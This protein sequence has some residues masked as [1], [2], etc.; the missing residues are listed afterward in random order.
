LEAI[1]GTEAAPLNVEAWI[2]GDPLTDE[3]L[4]G[5][6][7]L[8]DFW[9]VWCGPCIM[10]FPHLRKWQ[11]EYADRG[12]VIIGL[13]NYYNQIW[14][15]EASRPTRSKE[16]VTPEQ[17]QQMLQ[18]FAEHHQLDHRFAIMKDASLAEYY[19][20]SGIPHVV[21]IDREGKVQLM[22]VGSG[23]EAAKAI[24]AKIEQL[25]AEKA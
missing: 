20:V 12:L 18:K 5:K 8:L 19:G 15:D 9:A 24:E 14:D 1:V 4:K 13:T 11:E 22:R 7:V 21:V 10:T 25:I 17:E 3:D 2:N 6:V 16:K 23:E